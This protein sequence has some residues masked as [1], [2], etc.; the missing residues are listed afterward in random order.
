MNIVKMADVAKMA[1][2]SSS[3]VARVI[4]NSGYVSDETR[5][6]VEKVISELGY[7]QNRVAQGLK[8]RSTRMIGHV[9]P[10]SYINP[11]FA[12]VGGAVAK[13]ADSFGY[14]MLTAVSHYNAEKER[15]LVE[16]MVGRMA[17]G[18]VFTA[19]ISSEPELIDWLVGMGI[20]VIMV[21]RPINNPWID[22]VFINNVEGSFQATSHIFAKGH[23]RIGFIGRA[24]GED[25]EAQRYEG[26]RLAFEK[27]CIETN[28]KDIIFVDEYEIENGFKAMKNAMESPNPPKAFFISSDLLVCGALQYLYQN[29]LRVPEDVSIVG[30]DDTLASIMSPAITSVAFPIEEIGKVV[31][32][33]LFE[34]LKEKRTFAKTVTLSPILIQRDSVKDI[35]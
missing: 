28:P 13:A 20:P 22:K 4:N 34:R 9:I 12:Q 25:V 33:M 16:D 19:N 29:G 1:R 27:M 11:Y 2:V 10:Y 17:E 6:T 18:I 21:E 31:I 35:K 32:Q 15:M 23:K 8:N 7:V 14:H 3:T 30:F 26:Y 24:V 5:K